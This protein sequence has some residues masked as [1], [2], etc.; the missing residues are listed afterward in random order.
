VIAVLDR[1]SIEDQIEQEE[2][3]LSQVNSAISNADRSGSS[4]LTSPISGRVKR[5]FA[6]EDDV[7][8]QVVEQYGGV[9][10]L[11]VDGRLKVEFSSEKT[12][13]IGDSVTVSF[14]NYDKEGTVMAE[15]DG[16]YTVTIEDSADYP[17]DAEAVV[18]D[19]DGT[20][21]GC[22]YL[23]SN[24]PYLVEAS[25]GIA[26]EIRVTTGDYVDSGSTLLTR[27]SVSYNADYLD[28]LDQR[29]ELMDQLQ[30]LRSLKRDPR[31][32]SEGNGIVSEL[33]L[34]DDTVA[35]EGS[36]MYQLIST[37]S[38]WLKAEIDELDIADVAVGQTASIVFDAFDD[39]IYEGKVEK[40]SALGENTGGVTRYTVTISVPGID[41]VK[42]AM[43]ATATIVL[44]EQEDALLIPV[45]AVS[46][47][48]GEKCVSVWKDG[49]EQVVPVTLGLVNNTVAEVL[50][51]LSEGDEVLVDS[52][53][54]LEKMMDV[55]KQ[56]QEAV[57]GGD[58]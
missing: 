48:D 53:S 28:L 34:A 23:K 36:V 39:E 4:S 27:T 15:E 22:G 17:V 3:Q 26:D 7:L 14:L 21:L 56:S 1:D 20:E 11:S 47:V 49:Q 6:K 16:V 24:H 10:E 32:L 37:D 43:S 44:H 45:D 2:E 13:K 9:M 46:T 30:T 5:I 38:F 31:L 35:A 54:D 33:M 19:R 40:I 42:T 51:G 25:Y 12:L 41:K 50:E 8:T 57:R 52:K 18:K 29:E 55:M 58:N